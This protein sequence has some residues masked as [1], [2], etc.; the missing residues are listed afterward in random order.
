MLKKGNEVMLNQLRA[1]N[2]HVILAFKEDKFIGEYSIPK[3]AAEALNIKPKGISNVLCG[4]RK[5]YMGYTFKHKQGGGI[6][7][8]T[9]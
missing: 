3:D 7:N 6:T 9:N 5:T 1:S 8:P 2:K 4:Y